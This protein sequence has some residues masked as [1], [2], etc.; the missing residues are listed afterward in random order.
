[1]TSHP[2]SPKKLPERPL[3]HGATS[4]P[5]AVRSALLVVLLRE[6]SLFEDQENLEANCH[7]R[8]PLL[9]EAQLLGA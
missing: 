6:A 7:T 8:E 5:L 4:A 1:M 9:G 3:G 2:L